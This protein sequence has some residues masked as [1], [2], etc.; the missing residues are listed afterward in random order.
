MNLVVPLGRQVAAERSKARE[1][2][3]TERIRKLIWIRMLAFS[4]TIIL[5]LRDGDPFSLILM[6][7]LF[8]EEDELCVRDGGFYDI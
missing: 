4:T 5:P 1:R 8:Y 7:I 3:Y 2:S 6:F